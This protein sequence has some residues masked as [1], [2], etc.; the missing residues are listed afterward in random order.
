MFTHYLK[1]RKQRRAHQNQNLEE[2]S[3]VVV[4]NKT[5]VSDSVNLTKVTK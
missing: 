2:I 4:N 5:R 3:N 1:M